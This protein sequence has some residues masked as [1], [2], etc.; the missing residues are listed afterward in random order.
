MD[1]KLKYFD[2]TSGVFEISGLP[3]LKHNKSFCRLNVDWLPKFNE[4]V[5]RLSWCTAGAVVR[6]STDS[7]VIAVR[8][9]L[10]YEEDMPHMPWTG[11]SGVDLYLGKGKDKKFVRVAKPET[12]QT[13]YEAVFEGF[14]AKMQEWTINLPLYNGV[15]K[16]EIG[17]SPN[18]QLAKPSPYT[19]EKPI[20]FYGSSITQGGCASRPGNAYTHIISRWL[21]A[22]MVNL[23]FSGNAKGEPEMAQLISQIEM[24]AFVLDYDHNAP[25]VEHLK[26]THENFFKIIREAQPDLPIIIVTKPD[27]DSNVEVNSKRREVIYQTY[28]NALDRGDKNVYFVDGETLF[29]SEDRDACTVDG[30]HPNDLGFMRMAEHI[31]PTIKKALKL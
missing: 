16:L 6:F 12:N 14:E 3:W 29:G 25:T 1:T 22:N 8:V 30:C 23:G 2:V 4:N 31:Y 20:V 18:A 26:E 27:F 15:K 28:K 21:D 24:S 10:T 17:L 7:P 11:I 19:I 9:E 13:K 5:Q